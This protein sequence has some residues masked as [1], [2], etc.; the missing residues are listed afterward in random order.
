MEE[1]AI[2]RVY[3]KFSP[4]LIYR[5]S[6]D[7]R[8]NVREFGIHPVEQS[9]GFICASPIYTSLYFLFSFTH[10]SLSLVINL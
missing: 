8:A 4:V 6:I 2:E 1:F 9:Y 10:V 7:A 3:F 5:P